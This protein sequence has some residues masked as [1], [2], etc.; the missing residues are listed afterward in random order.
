MGDCDAPQHLLVL[1]SPAVAQVANEQPV[2]GNDENKRKKKTKE[3][4]CI[5]PKSCS[6]GRPTQELGSSL[7]FKYDLPTSCCAGYIKERCHIYDDL[8][9]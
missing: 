5:V 6:E 8:H 1:L 3:G 9:K 4:N 7:R 2:Y